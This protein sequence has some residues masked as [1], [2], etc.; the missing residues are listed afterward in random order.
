MVVTYFLRLFGMK[1]KTQMITN[2]VNQTDFLNASKKQPT[3]FLQTFNFM[4]DEG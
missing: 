4:V 2:V 3:V 1:T